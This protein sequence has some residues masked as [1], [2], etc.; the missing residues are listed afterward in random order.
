MKAR[1]FVVL[2]AV[3]LALGP[4]AF[5]QSRETGAIVGTITDQQGEALPGVTVTVSGTNLMGTRTFVTDRQGSY[6]F[7]AL[8]PGVYSVKAELQ[9]F[10]TAV[11]EEIR[12]TTTTRLTV[13]LTMVQ[14]VVEEEVTVQAHSPNT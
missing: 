11:R 4:A 14:S 7:P 9:G 12:L 3:L 2:A 13:D 8:P 10:K 6:R 5:S 1:S